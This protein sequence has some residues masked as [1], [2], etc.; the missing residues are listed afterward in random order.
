MASAASVTLARA[1]ELIDGFS[2]RVG[3]F[4]RDQKTGA[5]LGIAQRE[6]FPTASMIKLPILV[7]LFFQ[8]EA[9]RLA[10]AEPYVVHADD[11]VRG[12]GLLRHL[13]PGIRL[14]LRDLAYLMMSVSDNT[15]TN[16]IVDLVGLAAV[17]RRMEALG[18]PTLVLRHKIDFDHLWTEPEHLGVGTPEDF[19]GLLEQ[20][21]RKAILTPAA[22]EEML[23]MMAGVGADRAGRGER[24]GG[25]PRSRRPSSGRA[26]RSS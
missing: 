19:V 26:S 14:P 6:S 9:G 1:R 16:L 18:C 22:C 24:R 10:L 13:T 11:H 5:A 8:V 2:G 3:F 12:S 17:N 15:A 21:W 7:E 25:S 23:R 20:V 4:A